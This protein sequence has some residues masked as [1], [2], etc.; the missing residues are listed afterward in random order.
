MVKK[1]ALAA[2]EEAEEAK[3]VQAVAEA[4]RQKEMQAEEEEQKAA[5][6]LAN[7]DAAERQRTEAAALRVQ[8]TWRRKQ[9]MTAY[10]R[11]VAK[12]AR[13]REEAEIKAA[14]DIQRAWRTRERKQTLL[15]VALRSAYRTKRLRAARIRLDGIGCWRNKEAV[16][17][18]AVL[19]LQAWVA[20]ARTRM[21]TTLMCETTPAKIATIH[22]VHIQSQ[23]R[24]VLACTGKA[25]DS[26]APTNAD[27]SSNCRPCAFSRHVRNAC[28]SQSAREDALAVSAFQTFAGKFRLQA[29]DPGAWALRCELQAGGNMLRGLLY[30][31]RSTQERLASQRDRARS[32]RLAAARRT[33]AA[34][35]AA[36][37][38]VQ[39]AWRR[40]KGALEF[41]LFLKRRARAAQSAARAATTAAVAAVCATVAAAAASTEAKQALDKQLLDA[42]QNDEVVDQDNDSHCIDPSQGDIIFPDPVQRPGILCRLFGCGNRGANSGTALKNVPDPENE[43]VRSPHHNYG[44]PFYWQQHKQQHLQEQHNPFYWQ[45]PNAHTVNDD[46]EPKNGNA[47]SSN[48]DFESADMKVLISAVSHIAALQR[49]R[50]ARRRVRG[51]IKLKG[52]DEA[53]EFGGEG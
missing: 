23:M 2:K 28:S 53:I 31:R 36:A 17:L 24:R 6:G 3:R 43:Q 4:A 11:F 7:A 16:Q 5:A 40:K 1:R 20:A 26:G 34:Q 39:C 10:A 8:C 32:E 37:L 47:N 9:S 46:D 30:H 18:L 50:V 51:V 22:T 14:V 33:E 45:S 35:T 38:R 41:A 19:R 25:A 42:S 44:D 49:G 21:R 12:R 29:L 52:M 15:K 13:A 27:R 48:F